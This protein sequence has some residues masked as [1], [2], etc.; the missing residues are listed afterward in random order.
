MYC[1]TAPSNNSGPAAASSSNEKERD[2]RL[3]GAA[4]SSSNEKER[5]EL[6]DSS[7]ASSSNEKEHDELL[8]DDS[9]VADSVNLDSDLDGSDNE[10]QEKRD[11]DSEEGELEKF[12]YDAS[13]LEQDKERTQ[14]MIGIFSAAIEGFDLEK[15]PYCNQFFQKRKK[16]MM[17]HV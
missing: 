13:K 8:D 10:E 6:L 17:N 7:A 16:K 11:D 14:Y 4:A 15:E 1:T 12:V 5:D 9:N 3:D 2:D